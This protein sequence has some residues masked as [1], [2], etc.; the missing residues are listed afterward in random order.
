ME[1]IMLKAKISLIIALMSFGTA[2]ICSDEFY[3]GLGAGP[4]HADFKQRT[5]FSL[6]SPFPASDVRVIEK[7]HFAGKGHFYSFFAGLGFKGSLCCPEREDAYFGVELNADLRRVRFRSTNDEFVHLNFNENIYRMRRDL[8]VSILPGILFNDCT[9]FYARL[10]Y[11]NGRFK[12]TVSDPTLQS[13]HKNRD[14]FR[15]GLGFR[16]TICE[17]LAFRIDYSQT[18]YTRS[19][20]FFALPASPSTS[21]V[22]IVKSTMVTPYTHRFE[23]GI[24]YLF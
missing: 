4:Q 9:L 3:V 17:C 12:T 22:D 21:P 8:G 6:N 1:E 2:G 23:L 16:Q 19:K 13:I 15:Y 14:G 7:D 11:A 18:K 24:M 20:M 5:F 10:G